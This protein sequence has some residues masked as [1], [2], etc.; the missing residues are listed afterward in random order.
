VKTICSSSRGEVLRSAK[1]LKRVKT[2]RTFFLVYSRKV[3]LDEVVWTSKY[4]ID[5]TIKITSM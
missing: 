5:A 4:I 2:L 3:T 1:P